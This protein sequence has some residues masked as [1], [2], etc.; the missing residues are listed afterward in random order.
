MPK[1]VKTIA[2]SKT[3]RN[4]KFHD[5]FKNR[6][7]TDKQFIEAIKKGKYPRY[8]VKKIHGRETAVSKP[9]KSIDNNLD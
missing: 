2:Q 9:D 4:L 7:M 3:G 1:R 5:N 6:D 8:S